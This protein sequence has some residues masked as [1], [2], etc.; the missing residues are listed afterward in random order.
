VSGWTNEIA[1]WI[2]E[3]RQHRPV[4]HSEA[5]FQHALAWTAHQSNPS[6]RVRLETRTTP[7]MRLDLL[8]PNRAS[9][10]TS[11]WN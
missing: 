8:C 7:G 11:R 9:A 5:D 6:L 10:N 4:F 1:A 3:L 2:E